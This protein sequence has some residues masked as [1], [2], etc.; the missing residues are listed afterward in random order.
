MPTATT[1]S[2]SRRSRP[3]RHVSLRAKVILAFISIIL[4][5]IMGI[6][7]SLLQLTKTTTLGNNVIHHHQP[8]AQ[9]S[10]E[11]L[12]DVNQITTIVNDYLLTGE[13]KF[14]TNFYKLK[15]RIQAYPRAAVFQEPDALSQQ[16]HAELHQA[17]SLLESLFQHVEQLFYLREHELENYPGLEKASTLT[18]P[19]TLA[20]LGTLNELLS[21]DYSNYSSKLR[22][23]IISLLNELRY[24]WVQMNNAF[25]IFMITR[26]NN[27]LQNFYSY[28]ETNA[29]VHQK[30]RKLKVELGFDGL[31]Q[32]QELRE[33]RMQN[34]PQVVKAFQDD[35]WR[36]DVYIMK[37]KVYPLIDQIKNLLHAYSQ[38]QLAL[39]EQTGKSLAQQLQ[40]TKLISGLILLVGL[41]VAGLISWIILQALQPIAELSNVIRKV[42]FD[43]PQSLEGKLLHRSDEVGTLARA[44]NGMFARMASAYRLLNMNNM[45]LDYARQQAEQAS[46]VKTEFLNNMSHELRTPMNVIMGY[47]NLGE[48]EFEQTSPAELKEFFSKISQSS[49]HM[50]ELLNEL[51]QLTNYERQ[52]LKLNKQPYE[53]AQLVEHCLAQDRP[54]LA[55]KQLQLN[56]Q[57]P[58]FDTRALIDADSISKVI[59]QLLSNAIKYTPAGKTINIAISAIHEPAS[60]DEITALRL[61]VQDEGIGIPT[62][63]LQEIFQMFVQSTRTNDYSGGRGIGLAICKQII[64]AHHGRIWAENNPQLG[65]TFHFEVPLN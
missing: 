61:S 56:Y 60:A 11:L 38:A 24:S 8:A 14:K 12:A 43:N 49:E 45:E 1:H 51:L 50:L 31:K 42:S 59:G 30:L 34:V 32:L 21:E 47:A 5:M 39:S 64:D 52:D 58:D 36:R 22:L 29:R 20:Y 40:Q 13:E 9:A 53:L 33:L 7:G 26:A 17:A 15:Q 2:S 25:R 48:S 65:A 3:A 28:S 62:A 23:K 35:G 19:H 41:F 46:R 27:D 63:E 10:L 37:T 54:L 57:K 18:D 4:L 6:G 44:F 55:E 16:E